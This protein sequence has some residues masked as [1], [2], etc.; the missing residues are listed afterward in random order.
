MLLEGEVVIWFIFQQMHVKVFFG[1]NP[2]RK[3]VRQIFNGLASPLVEKT[4]RHFFVSD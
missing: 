4:T 1:E 3:I 2:G